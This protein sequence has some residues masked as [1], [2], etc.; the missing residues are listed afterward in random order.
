MLVLALYEKAKVSIN[1]PC[2]V[3]VVQIRK[4]SVR[5]G[6]VADRSVDIVRDDCK[7]GKRAN[8]GSEPL[9]VL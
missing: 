2:E 1:G 7:R 6:I 4:N 8:D 9:V 3:S 5:L